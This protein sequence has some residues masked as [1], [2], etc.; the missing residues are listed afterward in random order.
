MH[1]LVYIFLIDSIYAIALFSF[2]S[3]FQIYF[4]PATQDCALETTS[5]LVNIKSFLLVTYISPRLR[6]H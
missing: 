2:C 3:I 6:E 5:T 4:N 1:E